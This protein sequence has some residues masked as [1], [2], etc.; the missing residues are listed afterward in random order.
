MFETLKNRIIG[1]TRV[2]THNEQTRVDWLEKT[3]KKI[4]SGS[5][6]LDAGAGEQQFRRFC[7]HLTYVSQD[8]AQY[9]PENDP[10]GLQMPKW[11][12]GKLDIVSDIADIPEAAASFDA[13][14]CTEVFEHIINPREAIRE[15]S[16]LVKKDGWLIITAP[17]CSLTHFAPYHF[18]TGFNRFFYETDLPA[19]GFEIVELSPNGNYFEFL[20]QEVN[21]IPQMAG[22]YA[23]GITIKRSER[24]AMNVVLKLLER[25]SARNNRS[26]ELL[27]FGL[28]ILA[29]KTI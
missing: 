2:G 26:E 15:F 20:A 21:R 9:I 24:V 17:F 3:L 14:L 11:D 12:Y 27:N 25:L 1:Q 4:P 16:R 28:H 13:V 8:F 29:R 5:R 10:S 6:I 22:K 19:N 7:S 23:S 18:Y